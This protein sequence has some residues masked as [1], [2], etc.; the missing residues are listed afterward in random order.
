MN[1]AI[2]EELIS[3]VRLLA[4]PRVEWERTREKGKVPKPKAD[5]SILRIVESVLRKRLDEYKTTLEVCGIVAS[6][7]APSDLYLPGRR[8]PF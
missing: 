5:V 7:F 4:M 8:S 2:P 3:L 1:F 6:F